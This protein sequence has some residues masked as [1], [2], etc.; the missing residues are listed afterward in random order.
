MNK[1]EID[2]FNLEKRLLAS[3]NRIDAL[4]KKM[5]K[6][7]KFFVNFLLSKKIPLDFLSRYN[8]EKSPDCQFAEWMP[9]DLLVHIWRFYDMQ[10][11]DDHYFDDKFQKLMKDLEVYLRYYKVATEKWE[12]VVPEGED[13][14]A[15]YRRLFEDDHIILYLGETTLRFVTKIDKAAYDVSLKLLKDIGAIEIYKPCKSCD[16]YDTGDEE[17][18]LNFR[19]YCRKCKRNFNLKD[20]WKEKE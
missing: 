4:E 3:E 9:V 11:R 8:Q 2:L 5:E 1:E 7:D 17:G 13:K 19:E 16:H 12:Y 15:R 20:L 6:Y 18:H 14:V 10:K